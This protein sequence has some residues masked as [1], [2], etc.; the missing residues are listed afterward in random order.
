MTD[1]HSHILPGVDDGAQTTEESL[2]MLDLA[3]EGGT[4]AIVATPH[5]DL[6]YR[7]DPERCR[8]LIELL[9][10]QRPAGPRLYLGCEVHLTPE[11]IAKVLARPALY[12]LKGGDCLLLELPERI[13]PAMAAPAIGALLDAGLRVIIA[14]PERNSYIQ[15]QRS[16]A[17]WLVERGCFL[18]ITGQSLNGGFGPAASSTAVH[19]L[20]R[21][22]AH[23]IASDTHG[24][25]RR[26]PG[27]SRVF[28]TISKMHGE[29][30]A[31]A[32][33]LE[34]PE[35]ALT[36]SPICRM[37]AAEG[38]FAFLF[39]RTSHTNGFRKQTIPQLP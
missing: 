21:R 19:L 27:L 18:Q 38:F 4:R 5:S 35:A 15:H 26:R 17:D 3:A 28:H 24:A 7:F 9:R 25:T 31:R 30:A 37:P 22:L 34:N 33:F 8:D 14:H 32:L 1:L 36:G 13:M 20:R 16:Y 12:T 10:E 23:F 29:R 11:N 2:Q 6:R 39:S